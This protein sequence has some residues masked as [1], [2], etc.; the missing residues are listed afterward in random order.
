MRPVAAP[1]AAPLANRQAAIKEDQVAIAE[2]SVN[3]K[4]VPCIPQHARV[5]ERKQWSPSSHEK[6]VPSIVEIATS[7]V[8]T[9]PRALADRAGNADVSDHREPRQAI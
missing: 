8:R 9:I 3:E 1:N 4:S 2:G 7:L 6:I 5:A